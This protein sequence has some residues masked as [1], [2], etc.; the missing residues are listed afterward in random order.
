ML[1]SHPVNKNSLYKHR[2][3]K[4]NEALE[5]KKSHLGDELNNLLLL[6]RPANW[7]VMAQGNPG[8]FSS[9]LAEP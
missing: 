1:L 3:Q 7:P 8:L 2:V 4:Y 5:A 9:R 6:I